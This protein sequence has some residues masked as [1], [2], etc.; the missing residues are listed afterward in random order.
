M[1]TNISLEDEGA[2]SNIMKNTAAFMSQVKSL[3]WLGKS[4]CRHEEKKKDQEKSGERE[5]E[6]PHTGAVSNAASRTT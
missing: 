1:F 2:S 3:V 6:E 5:V 4:Y